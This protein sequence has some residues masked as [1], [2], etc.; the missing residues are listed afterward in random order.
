MPKHRHRSAAPLR[1][2]KYVVEPQRRLYVFCEG[3]KTEP[4]YFDV[5]RAR[6]DSAQ[7]LVEATGVGGVP[8]TVADKAIRHAKGLRR[9]MR[10]RAGGRSSFEEADQVWV[11]FD[12]DHH[13]DVPNVVVRCR[14]NKVEVAYSNPCFELWLVLHLEPYDRPAE[15]SDVQA[16]FHAL[17]PAYDHEKSPAPD[18]SDLLATVAVA[19]RRASDQAQRRQKEGAPSGNPSTTVFRLLRAISVAHDEARRST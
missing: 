12:Q 10:S 9:D 15:A 7:I 17:F 4:A 13:P 1:R 3:A 19:E 18:F 2:R 14:D 6:F 8:S 11:V 5:V 16:R